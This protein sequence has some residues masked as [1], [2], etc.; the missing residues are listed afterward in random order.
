[1]FV[2]LQNKECQFYKAF[3]VHY[4]CAKLLNFALESIVTLQIMTTQQFLVT[5]KF[6]AVSEIDL[7]FLTAGVIQNL[8]DWWEKN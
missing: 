6:P 3:V 2:F 4:F 5:T 1:M 8:K 7:P